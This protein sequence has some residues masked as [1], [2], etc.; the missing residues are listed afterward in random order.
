MQEERALA[1]SRTPGVRAAAP[2]R[3]FVNAAWL[4]LATARSGLGERLAIT[5]GSAPPAI[6]LGVC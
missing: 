4:V 5:P 3:F 2:S 6:P 1:W